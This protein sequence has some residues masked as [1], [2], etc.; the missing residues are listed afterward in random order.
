MWVQCYSTKQCSDVLLLCS[1]EGKLLLKSNAAE[2]AKAE[3]GL[4]RLLCSFSCRLA[5]TCL[6]K[7]VHKLMPMLRCLSA[8]LGPFSGMRVAWG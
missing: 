7:D 6:T 8:E 1:L 2:L 4:S 5:F 3:A